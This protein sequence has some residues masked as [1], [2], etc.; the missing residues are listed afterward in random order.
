MGSAPPCELPAGGRDEG[1][2]L[3]PTSNVALLRRARQRGNARTEGGAAQA[4]VH[5]QPVDGASEPAGPAPMA[6]H[7]AMTTEKA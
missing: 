6:V 7:L 3:V 4:D 1:Q 5:S 2:R